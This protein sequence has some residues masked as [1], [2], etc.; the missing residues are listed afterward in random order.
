VTNAVG[1]NRIIHVLLPLA[2][3]VS[4]LNEVQ[5]I[6][7][8]L[9]PDEHLEALKQLEFLGLI[10][11]RNRTT[12]ALQTERLIKLLKRENK[13]APVELQHRCAI[14]YEFIFRTETDSELEA[15]QMAPSQ[16]LDMQRAAGQR[17]T[18]PAE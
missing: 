9:I 14:A 8:R 11:R 17:A 7:V 1:E 2:N 3:T 5:P 15:S 13:L 16:S 12:C 4:W 6:A 18:N 10:F